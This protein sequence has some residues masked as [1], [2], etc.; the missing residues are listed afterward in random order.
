MKT[1]KDVTITFHDGRQITEVWEK[2]TFCLDRVTFESIAKKQKF[3]PYVALVLREA[4]KDNMFKGV[5]PDAEDPVNPVDVLIRLPSYVVSAL[6]DNCYRKAATLL[7]TALLF[8]QYSDL[9]WKG[10]CKRIKMS[11]DLI[12]EIKGRYPKYTVK[13]EKPEII[14]L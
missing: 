13:Y 14:S 7:K 11:D 6:G 1:D 3:E 4:V 12:S 10:Y 9:T 8:H 5:Q 2:F